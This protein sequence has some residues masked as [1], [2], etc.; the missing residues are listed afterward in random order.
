MGSALLCGMRVQTSSLGDMAS[1]LLV[2]GL[3]GDPEEQTL[4]LSF[5]FFSVPIDLE[6]KLTGIG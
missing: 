1:S 6:N 5:R 3:G 4:T 2:Y